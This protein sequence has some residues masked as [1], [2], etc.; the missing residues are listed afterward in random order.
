MGHENE[1]AVLYLKVKNSRQ[2]DV[3]WGTEDAT[4]LY[5]QTRR[6]KK[7]ENLVCWLLKSKLT[8]LFADIHL[9]TTFLVAIVVGDA[10]HLQCM[11]FK[12]APLREWLVTHLTSIRTNTCRV[13]GKREKENGQT[14]ENQTRKSSSSSTSQL[15]FQVVS[16]P[17]TKMERERERG[18]KWIT[19]VVYRRITS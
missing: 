5:F 16:L 7:E 14:R 8:T 12:W 4:M 6:G 3:M 9:V 15:S 10:M 13:R 17:N 11:R 1:L 19:N 2:N 18:H